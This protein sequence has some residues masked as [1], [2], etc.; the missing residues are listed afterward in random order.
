MSAKHIPVLLPDSMV[1][2]ALQAADLL[3]KLPLKELEKLD[4]KFQHTTLVGRPKATVVL[5]MSCLVGFHMIQ[6]LK[7]ARESHQTGNEKRPG[8]ETGT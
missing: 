1:Q 4:Q 2:L 7:E 5:E 8:G 3:E 6:V